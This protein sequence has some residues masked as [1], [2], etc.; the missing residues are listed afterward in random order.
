MNHF[1]VFLSEK[2]RYGIHLYCDCFS[3][4]RKLETIFF[5]H[6]G[7]I[8]STFPISRVDSIDTLTPEYYHV[9]SY[10]KEGV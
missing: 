1:I 9:G 2:D 6:E 5:Y 10:Q 3:V 7:C 4:D 8:I